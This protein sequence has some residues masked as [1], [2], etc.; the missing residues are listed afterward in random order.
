M[1]RL[2]HYLPL[3]LFIVL[4]LGLFTFLDR[5]ERDLRSVLLNKDFPNFSLSKLNNEE[6]ITKDDLLEL[7]SLLF[8]IECLGYLVRCLS[9]RTP[10]LN[11]IK[12]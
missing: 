11:G 9:S 7:P 6:V 3:A 2:T 10:F 5:E 1:S 8:F 4:I 12:K